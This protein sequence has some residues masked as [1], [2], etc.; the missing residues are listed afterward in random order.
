MTILV[1]MDKS[2]SASGVQEGE[3]LDPFQAIGVDVRWGVVWSVLPGV[4]DDLLGLSG[5]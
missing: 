2:S 3:P 1:L 4:Q 5:V